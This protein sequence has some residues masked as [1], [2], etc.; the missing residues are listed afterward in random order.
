LE[1]LPLGVKQEFICDAIELLGMYP[2]EY[3]RN[4]EEVKNSTSSKG[5]IEGASCLL[6]V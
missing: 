4:M 6:L 2:P 1:E 3:V 5:S